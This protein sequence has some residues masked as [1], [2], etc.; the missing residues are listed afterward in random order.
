M[1]FPQIKN[2]LLALVA[3]SRPRYSSMMAGYLFHPATTAWFKQAFP[4]PTACQERA[5]TALAAGHHTLVA[6]PTGSGKTLAAFLS[7]IDQLV[8]ESRTQDLPDA[9]QVVYV[10]PLKALSND[11]ERNLEAPLAGINAQLAALGEPETGIR[12]AVRT[13]DTPQ[14][15]RALMRRRPPHIL[16]TT[17]E[18]LYIL[19]TSDSGRD[20]LRGTRTVIVDEI[21]AVAG[22]KRGAHLSLSLERLAALCAV[23]PLRIGL[24]A[25]QRPLQAI[26]DY[27]IGQDAAG[28]G[29]TII[30]EGHARARDLALELPSAPLDAVL[31]GE[32]A[33]EIYDRIAA[34]IRQHH[35]T[36]VFVNTRR[37]AERVAKALSD[38]ISAEVV[39]SHHGSMSK[40]LRLRAEQRLKAGELKALVATA[41]LELGIDIGEVDLVC[42]LGS[43][44]A[45]ATLLQRVGRSGHQIDGIAKGRLFP[46]TRDEL[47]EC[48]ALLDMTRRGEL[49]RIQIC[50]PSLDVLAQQVVAEVACRDCGYDELFALCR[51][52]YPYRELDLAAFE[53]VLTMLGEG[54]SFAHGKRSAYLHLD[55]INRIARPRA[56]AR[57]TAVTCG[58]AI[59]DTADY[60]VILEPGGQTVGTVNE[61][62]A[63]ESLPGDIFQLG[64]NSWRVMKIDSAAVRVADAENQPPNMPFWLGEAPGRTTEMSYAVSRLRSEFKNYVD[65]LPESARAVGINHWLTE[66]VGLSHAAAQQIYDYLLSGYRSLGEMPTQETLVIER[67]FD[68][69]GGMQLVIHAPLGSRINRAWGLAL[70]KRFCRQF[71]FELQ[72]AA[73]DDAIVIS[74]G[75]VHS[76]PLDDV[77]RYLKSDSAR[78]ILTQALLAAP[79]FTVRW[80]WVACCALALQR[81]RASKKTPPRLLRMQA[82][83]LVAVVFPDQLACA[84]NLQGRR[85]IPTHPL[86]QQTIEDCLS[87]AMDIAGLEAL[88]RA[89]ERGE[90]KLVTRDLTAPSPFAQAVLN[91]N[92][93]AFLDD[94]PLEERRTRAVQSR[95]WIDP[96]TAKDLGALDTAAITRV[97]TEAW[98]SPRNAEELHDALDLLGVVTPSDLAESSDEP[99][100]RVSARFDLDFAQLV[101]NGRAVALEV[102]AGAPQLWAA[103]ENLA[104]ALAIWPA[105]KIKAGLAPGAFNAAEVTPE[106]AINVIVRG[107]LEVSGPLTQQMLV[108]KL[109]LTQAQ[110]EQAL[111][112]LESAGIILRGQF[113]AEQAALEWCDRR[114]LM[115]IHRYTLNRLRAEI[116]PVPGAAF[117]RFLCQWQYAVPTAQI[118]GLPA[119]Q[120]ILDMLAGFEAAAPAWEDS[121]L[122]LRLKDY[123]RTLLDQLTSGGRFS[124]LRLSPTTSERKGSYSMRV[125]PLAIIPRAEV[126]TWRMFAPR[127]PSVALNLSSVGA[128]IFAY[129]ARSGASFVDDIVADCGL[130]NAQAEVGLG[131]LVAQGVIN[132]DSFQGMRL[133]LHATAKSRGSRGTP[134]HRG[135]SLGIADSG[136]WQVLKPAPTGGGAAE[137]TGSWVEC[138]TRRLLARYGIVFKKL[139]ERESALPPWRDVLACLRR[140]EARGEIRGG[141]FV[142][143]FSGEQFA[144]PEALELLRKTRSEPA[145]GTVVTVSPADPLNLVGIL[146]PGPL[147]PSSSKGKIVYLD[148]V[149]VAIQSGVELNP[150]T[151]IALT[152][153]VQAHVRQALSR[154]PPLRRGTGLRPSRSNGFGA[155]RQ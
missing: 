82:E 33:S 97:R 34:L 127:D 126:A 79:L 103:S 87:E 40:E 107:W 78:D 85:E 18:S 65:I 114:L 61:D 134:R 149:P 128:K 122:P 46:Q 44:R 84:E 131:E 25:T 120:K 50:G 115:R 151:P 21:H 19:L 36:L 116:E 27:L 93:Y 121:I 52:S 32:S 42:Q 99:L 62:F 75:A 12:V 51:K 6:A 92:P 4:A 80:R 119:L 81:F 77:W 138:I 39:S 41:S 83:D 89:I 150:L 101:A 109:Q 1:K 45:L 88:L 57:L 55:R 37:M 20:M 70:R 118:E 73:V 94:A 58:G 143:G 98:P 133:L 146:T 28:T 90:I 3:G 49:D 26:A 142:A 60:A 69:S 148:G 53:Q 14:A 137:V 108:A 59:P 91:A 135:Q 136:R 54:Y 147:I 153:D 7:M 100:A 72:A 35:T 5:W 139:L 67:F 2:F 74:L 86:V 22:S 113:T 38:R 47:I 23:P 145:I 140:L 8:C 48:A 154:I 68:E 11:V 102:A 130:L 66:Q 105:L 63:I 71:N 76:F 110:A 9:V 56:G 10:S 129:L 106:S 64:N 123:D 112:H 16:V 144:L 117:I 95:R 30:D 96:E 141:R 152:A 15:V 104:Q 155:H 24:S 132:A 43:T 29:C 111:L 124:W 125:T 17:P 31:S 13:G